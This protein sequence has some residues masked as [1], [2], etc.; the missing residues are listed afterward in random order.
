MS[1]EELKNWENPVEGAQGKDVSSL[2]PSNPR[3]LEPL[4]LTA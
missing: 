4:R 1:Y 2:D 3:I